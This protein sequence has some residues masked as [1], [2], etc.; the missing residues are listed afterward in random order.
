M[1]KDVDEYINC[2]KAAAQ[3][4]VSVDVHI[5]NYTVI[6]TLSFSINFYFTSIYFFKEN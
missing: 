2:L 4:P 3:V 5:L 6:V 1:S